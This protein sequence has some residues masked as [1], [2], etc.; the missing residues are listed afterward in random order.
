MA[1]M[2]QDLPAHRS[3]GGEG[4]LLYLDAEDLEGVYGINEV[5]D[6]YLDFEDPGFW[7][8]LMDHFGSDVFALATLR[9][10]GEVY[11]SVAVAFKGQSSFQRAVEEGSEKL[12]FSV[13]LDEYIDGQDI[14]GYNNFNFNNAYGDLSFMREVIYGLL[15]R[16]FVPALKGSFIRLWING[17]DWG[18]YPNIQQLNGD[19]VK[20]WFPEKDGIRWRADGPEGSG[21]GG[22]IP[23]PPPQG[24][25]VELEGGAQWGDGTAALNY[26][27]QDSSEYANYYTVKDTDLDHAWDYLIQVCSVLNQTP[28]E[29]LKDSLDRYLDLDAT[30]WFLAQE[31]LFSDDD[32][33]VYKGKMDYYLFM[34]QD[35]RRML[36]L[37]FDGNSAMM[38]RNVEWSPF[39]N[40]DDANYPLLNRLLSIPELRQRYIAHVK[41]ILETAFDPAVYGPLIDQVDGLI[42]EEVLSDPKAGV[43]QAQYDLAVNRLRTFMQR[44]RN[45]I[46][47]N[48]E[49]TRESPWIG[50]PQLLEYGDME[51]GGV[52]I[53]VEASHPN[54]LERMLLYYG[55][56]LHGPFQVLELR[57]DGLESDELAGDGR[58]SALIPA[59][60]AG[61]WVR[62][63]I[64]ARAADGFLSASFMPSGASYEVYLYQEAGSD[65]DLEGLVI[66]EFMASNKSS[67]ADEAGEFDDWVEVHNAS[68]AE[69]DLA[70]FFLS[71]DSMDPL[72]WTF[73]DTLLH[74][75]EYLVIWTDSDPEQGP[76]HARF[77]LSADGEEVLLSD[78]EGK[79][80]DQVVFGAQE[81]DVSMGRWPNATGAFSPMAPS[82]QAK[83]TGGITSRDP[84]VY[85]SANLVAYPNPCRDLLH[86]KGMDCGSTLLLFNLQGQVVVRQEGQ[87]SLDLSGLKAGMY[88]L[89]VGEQSL[90]IVKH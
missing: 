47:S 45:V 5:K 42:R 60:L 90:R 77:K 78:V 66:N 44:R 10:E 37:E 72:K 13:K 38:L 35:S 58:Y 26:L 67:R 88:I 19:F 33:Y 86:V 49:F 68:A 27:G 89:R 12:S 74:P 1:G 14:E 57:D 24:G 54:G 73:P 22:P 17:E 87:R 85:A 7:Q 9:Y 32:S 70:G 69:I 46:L 81:A 71:D 8:F 41:H 65:S 34:D 52:E 51:A 48:E 43:G 56:G 79:L 61:S 39:M 82:F 50:V 30:L 2:G 21:G 16:K 20:E 15:S 28:L 64:E 75:G 80:I 3:L 76:L 6:L 23:P 63:Y 18:L 62:Y 29:L 11:D 36:P 55:T 83:N 31:N 59:Q 84:E 4:N 40:E 53:Q 25:L